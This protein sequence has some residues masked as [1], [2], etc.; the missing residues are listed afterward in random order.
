MKSLSL[1]RRNFICALGALPLAASV[2]WPS[3]AQYIELFM[4]VV[5][6]LR[7]NASNQQTAAWR[8][9]VIQKLDA[10]MSVTETT[11]A[12]VRALRVE[13]VDLFVANKL[14][15]LLSDL[16]TK[17]QMLDVSL[18]SADSFGR[19]PK[20]QHEKINFI[21]NT[22]EADG[23]DLMQIGMGGYQPVFCGFAMLT[24]IYKILG[25]QKA[26]FDA[27]ADKY[28]EYFKRAMDEKNA[29]SVGQQYA[30]ARRI[31]AEVPKFLDQV[32]ACRNHCRVT[33][34]SGPRGLTQRKD[35]YAGWTN[36]DRNMGYGTQGFQIE[37]YNGQ[38]P[39]PGI[40]MND[41]ASE[42]YER[43]HFYEGV[44]LANTRAAELRWA[45]GSVAGLKRSYDELTAIVDA[46]TSAKNTYQS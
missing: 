12:E 11:L 4:K 46:I 26:S 15:S 3:Q 35:V 42:A 13:I 8:A 40:G 19:I 16:E 17:R 36:G 5:A 32:D 6:A 1:S 44:G 10:I 24:T 18:A 30:S 33:E 23:F 22:T 45:N 25:F 37:P 39:F 29:G 34:L 2:P 41:F 28:L 38:P 20:E 14:A 21:A 9:Q 43:E 27:L 7:D 31:I